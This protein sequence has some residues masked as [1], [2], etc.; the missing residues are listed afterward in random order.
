MNTPQEAKDLVH[1][2]VDEVMNGG[3]MDT[4]DDFFVPELAGRM[5]RL[6]GSFRSAFPDWR[7]E[8]VELVAESNT[9]RDASGVR[10]RT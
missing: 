7:E 3:D 9:E 8:I 1:Q 2:P 6:F 4:I 5:K 10:V